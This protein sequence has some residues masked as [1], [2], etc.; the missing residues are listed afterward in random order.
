MSDDKNAMIDGYRIQ[1][2]TMVAAVELFESLHSTNDHALQRAADSDCPRP[3]L[4]VAEQQTAGR[5]RGANRWWSES[6][7]LTFSLLLEGGT[8]DPAAPI[9]L[10][11][12]VAVCDAIRSLHAGL[13]PGVKWPNDVFLDGRKIAGILI[14]RPSHDRRDY[15][16]GIGLNV[17][18]SLQQAPADVADV[19]T[20]LIDVAGSPRDLHAVLAEL[21]HQIDRA[22]SSLATNPEWLRARWRE[23]CILDGRHV[24]VEAGNR[25]VAGICRGIDNSGAL[26][27][28]T[29]DGVQSCI[30]GSVASFE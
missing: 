17:N 15:V 1:R 12:G 18:N 11:V 19:A 6:G 9:S 2:E 26:L 29:P 4:V 22:V 20:S 25:Q 28:E 30:S 3:L 7:A 21:L 8:D 14:E 10:A 23:L 5:G 13:E 27:V 24:L 16:V